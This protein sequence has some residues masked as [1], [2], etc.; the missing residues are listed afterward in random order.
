MQDIL[1]SFVDYLAIDRRRQPQT[2][3]TYK[4]EITNFL[5]FCDRESIYIESCTL[6]HL[7]H[8]IQTRSQDFAQQSKQDN[9]ASQLIFLNKHLHKRTI[10]KIISI[11]NTF[12]CYCQEES[13]R[14]DNPVDMIFRPVISK[15]TPTV[16]SIEEVNT[17]LE[18]I[19]I[20]KPLGIRD[21]AMLEL[22]YACGLRVS[23]I[24]FLT[25]SQLNIEEGLIRVI[26]KGDKE[27]VVPIGT[28]A[29]K[30]L[31]MYL[32][33][34]RPLLL[35][36][37]LNNKQNK[38]SNKGKN[39]VFLNY[40]GDVISRKGIWKNYQKLLGGEASSTKLHTL[41]HSFATHLLEGGMDLRS[42]QELL[43]HEDLSTTQVYTHIRTNILKMA[44]AKH[45]P[46]Q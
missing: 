25:I 19:D 1:H 20:S 26:G 23:E 31:L 2:I 32:E 45:H 43:G 16:L 39:R 4:G 7:H 41:R 42:V 28:Q 10:S 5:L 36:K 44:H 18:T 37:R 12:F 8:Y 14:L 15:S 33:Q 13:I 29:K 21:R 30:W 11:L 38:V 35:T 27:R 17:I 3:E 22:I 6:E 34:V 9:S 40:R 24:V 46:R